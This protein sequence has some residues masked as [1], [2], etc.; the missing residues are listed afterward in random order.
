MAT[1]SAI[2]VTPTSENGKKNIFSSYIFCYLD[3]IHTEKKLI[4]D[5]SSDRFFCA[6]FL[7]NAQARCAA[8]LAMS[9][10]S[11]RCPP[12]G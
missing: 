3:F 5:F 7:K 1:D 8:W 11:V 4:L 10:R 6:A 2:S 12:V 9:V